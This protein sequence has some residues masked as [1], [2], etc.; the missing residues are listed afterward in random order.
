VTGDW[1][2]LRNQELH[3]CHSAANVGVNQWGGGGWGVGCVLWRGQVHTRNL[4]GKPERGSPPIRP[5]RSLEDIIKTDLKNVGWEG[6]DYIR[7]ASDM[8]TWRA[9]VNTVMNLPV[10]IKFGDVFD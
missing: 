5:G 10:S 2:K 4:V 6:V 7:M 8:D 3:V 1:R 9:V